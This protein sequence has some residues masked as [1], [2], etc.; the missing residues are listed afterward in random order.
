MAFYEVAG[1]RPRVHP[2]TFVHP[3]ASLIGDVEVGP[4]C[5]IGAGASLRA[6]WLSIRVGAGSN[7][8]DSCTVHGYPGVTVV[9]EEGTHMGHGSIVHGAHVGRNV[10]VGM[11]AVVQDDADLGEGCVIGSG[12]V[13]PAGMQVPA[14]MLVVGV[15]GRIVGDVSAALRAGKI[16]GTEWYQGL[17]RRCSAE[18]VVAEETDCLSE[19]AGETGWVP[20]AGADAELPEAFFS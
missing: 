17:A 4:G 8:Q 6:D 9:L 14:G 15:P 19:D 18:F 3:L 1:R 11:N 13:V 2:S 16:A 12:C 7:V 5:Y 20:W 10:L